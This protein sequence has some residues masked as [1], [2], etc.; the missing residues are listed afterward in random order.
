MYEEQEIL[1]KA[2]VRT[3]INR[4][5]AELGH[6]PVCWWGYEAT[7][8]TASGMSTGNDAQTTQGRAGLQGTGRR[9]RRFTPP[10]KR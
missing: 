7:A 6:A 1:Q 4:L 5:S 2:T 8:M 9:R 3:M 10:N